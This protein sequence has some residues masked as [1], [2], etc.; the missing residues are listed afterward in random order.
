MLHLDPGFYRQATTDLGFEEIEA[1]VDGALAARQELEAFAV[2]DVRD[3]ERKAALL[4]RAEEVLDDARLVGDLVVGAALSQQHDA[5]PL[6]APIAGDVRRL[7]AAGVDET[8]RALVRTELRARA[9]GWLAEEPA[10]VREATEVDFGDRRPLHWPLEFP[11]VFVRGGFD[12]VLGNPPFQGGQKIT[13]AL[14]T[15]YRDYLVRQVAGGARG[16][17]DLIAYF[18]LRASRLLRPGGGFGLIAT[19]TLAQGDTREVGLDQLVRNG[20]T[21]HRAVSS[22]PWPGGSNLEMATVWAH[23]NGWAGAVALDRTPVAGITTSLTPRSRVGGG[24]S[25]SPRRRVSRS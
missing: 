4:A 1:A 12:A 15:R 2:R 22:E 3:A 19:N 13:G 6:V 5:D 24:P 9:D 16:S 7:L 20:M 17:A 25:G 10:G 23:R 18:Y 11:E 14:G 21:L 8:E